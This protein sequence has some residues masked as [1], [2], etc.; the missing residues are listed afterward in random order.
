MSGLCIMAAFCI[1]FAAISQRRDENI[2][3][4]HFHEREQLFY[5]LLTSY[6]I[7][8]AGLRIHYN[9]TDV[10][11][12]SFISCPSFPKV[13]KVINWEFGGHPGFK[14]FQSLIK[15]FS[16][17][18]HVFLMISSMVS[19]YPTIWFI[20][21]YTKN[22]T[23]SIFIF[24]ML[25]YYVFLLA[26]IKQTIATSFALIA[27]DRYLNGKKIRYLL[28]SFIGMTFHVYV[29]LYLIIPFL[30]DRVPW[31][32]GTW[33]M[34]LAAVILT[35]GF[36]FVI[37]SILGATEA[38]GDTYD[39][40]TFTDDGINI[41]RVLVYFVPVIISFVWRNHLFKY[42][43]KSENLFVNLSIVCALIMFL[44]LFGTANMFAR[45]AIFFEPAVLIALPWMLYKLKGRLSG[46][47]LTTGSYVAFPIFFYF[48]MVITA[49]F[50]NAYSSISLGEFFN[51]LF[52]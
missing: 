13:F 37:N 52:N 47:V 8:F 33:I 35:Y 7:I 46:L 1:A 22:F 18:Y 45:L 51:S 28:Y 21:K 39:R 36:D 27:L 30:F 5:A 10:Y 40:D 44:G 32:K 6:M 31:Q 2:G 11:V 26:A 50:D 19:I 42:S 38:L 12:S 17:N 4:R 49:D 3:Q 41:F 25:G 16:D 14:I 29:M 9:D 23:L 24:F 43:S 20:R 15:I 48:Q 34:I